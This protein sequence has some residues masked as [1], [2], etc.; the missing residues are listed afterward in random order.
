MVLSDF[1]RIKAVVLDVDGVLTDGS[2]FVNEQGEQLRTFYVRDGYAIQLAM[3]FGL[4][5]WVITGGKSV[6]VEK[7]MHGLGVKEVF[8]GIVDKLGHVFQLAEKYGIDLSEIMYVGDDMPDLL[9][10]KSIGLPVCPKDAA[11]EIKAVSK[12]ISPFDGGRGV[13]R[14][15]LEKVLKL[16][17][18]WSSELGIKSV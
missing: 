14:D 15:V 8:S 16:Q 9:P 1:K 13:V 11:E 5:I 18:K 17:G 12:Y 7:R 6:G 3:Q 10:M 4:H 2:V